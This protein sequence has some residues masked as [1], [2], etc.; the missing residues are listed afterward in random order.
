MELS[1]LSKWIDPHR[2]FRF[3]WQRLIAWTVVALLTY[4]GFELQVNLATIS[5]LYLLVVVAT[6]SFGSFWQASLTSL[7]A[8]ACLD[9]F[10]LPPLFRFNIA[11]PQDWVALGTFEATA[12]AI[13]RL[14]AREI[15]SAREAAIHRTAM[16][17]LYELSRS[18]LLPD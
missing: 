18:S 5:S 2:A 1:T 13:G 11:D 12:L 16:E 4:C 9:L 17:R 7:V 10:F 6:A 15:R 14:S 8:V 3:V